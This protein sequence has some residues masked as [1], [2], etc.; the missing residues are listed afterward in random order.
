[1]PFH[2]RSAC[3][4]LSNQHQYIRRALLIRDPIMY[5][6]N[7]HNVCKFSRKKIPPTESKEYDTLLFNA[8]VAPPSLSLMAAKKGRESGEARATTRNR[9]WRLLLKSIIL[10]SNS[11]N[12]LVQ[13]YTDSEGLRK[14][15]KLSLHNI[16]LTKVSRNVHIFES[17]ER[18]KAVPRKQA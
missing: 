18:Y 17:R 15:L 11:E 13:D 8:S 16:T 14:L 12:E 5:S 6:W 4:S 7:V 3:T 9:K 1:M 10:K 2:F